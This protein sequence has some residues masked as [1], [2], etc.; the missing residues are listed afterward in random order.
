MQDSV[1]L[2]VI[3]SFRKVE[4]NRLRQ[5]V[6]S[7]FHNQRQDVVGL[8]DLLTENYPSGDAAS[9][10]KE[11][12]FAH[13]YPGEPY[14]EK[15]IRYT[16]SFLYTLIKS[17]LSYEEFIDA[18]VNEKIHCVK[19]LRKRG[20]TRPFERE[21][22]VVKQAV[23]RQPW[24]DANY[25]FAQYL[26]HEERYEFTNARRRTEA[27]SF[28]EMAD[29]LTVYFVAQ[30]LKQACA[31][32]SHKA[33][34]KA[35]YQ[36]DFITQIIDFLQNKNLNDYPVIEVYYHCYMALSATG[37]SSSFEKVKMLIR[38]NGHFFPRD[39]LKDIYLLAINYCIRQLNEGHQAFLN[40]VF[41][42]YQQGLEQEVFFEN[43]L[44]SRF[45][46]NNILRA[47][48]ALKAFDW[49]EQFL[50]QYRERIDPKY[51][52]S[53][54]N[55]NLAVLYFRKPDYTR[56]MHLLQRA[57][58]KD[59]LHNLDGRRMLL[60]IYFDLGEWD[61]LGSLLDSFKT[62]LYRQKKVL[63]YHF[64][65]Y[66]NLLKFAKRIMN[67]YP[68]DDKSRDN[69]FRDIENTALLTEKEW[70]LDQLK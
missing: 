69:L 8:L 62:Y 61:A 43:G 20:L 23:D 50:H 21:Y 38:D 27:E 56:A 3:S 42:L 35:E 40:E 51:R 47:A 52:D 31:A 57:E 64:D 36:L 2:E 25:H 39:E 60:R 46:Y 48:L 6:V 67:L 32:L 41:G 7:P 49:A 63:G 33:V 24:R 28:Q 4:L 26:L 55:Y 37:L 16:M 11:I 19:A 5:F 15:K 45:T 22:A 70:L 18:P 29:E 44:L 59:P 10:S 66:L 17:F 54:F 65:S 53:V 13:V 30:R 9:F 14:D 12:A 34:S 58:F 1:L 68:S